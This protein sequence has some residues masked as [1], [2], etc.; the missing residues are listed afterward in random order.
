[1]INILKKHAAKF[2]FTT[3]PRY[4]VYMFFKKCTRALYA[5]W[6]LRS[7]PD[8]PILN[9]AAATVIYGSMEY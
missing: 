5:L 9:L 4:D 6:M 1:M 2:K 7:K 8:R 3:V